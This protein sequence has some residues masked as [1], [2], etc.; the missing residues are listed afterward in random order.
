M[1][2]KQIPEDFQ[3]EELTAVQAQDRGE[4]AF[5]RLEKV[6]WTT[7]DA[8]QL[9]AR[10]WKFPWKAVSY[11]GLKDR[12]ASTIQYL[13][14]FRGPRRNFVQDRLR[15]EYLGQVFDPFSSRDMAGNRFQI[16][17]RDLTGQQ[18]AEVQARLTLLQQT[19]IPNYFDD[20]RFGSVT[21]DGRFVAKEMVFGRFEAALKLALIE[22][23]EFDN[24]DIK[25]EK[26]ILREHWNDWPTCKGKLPRSHARSLVDYLVHH[27][28]DYRGTLAR[29]RPELQGMYLSAYQSDLW[30]RTL[31]KWLRASLEPSVLGQIQLHHQ[32]LVVPVQSHD[33]LESLKNTSIALACPRLKPQIDAPWWPHLEAVLAEEGLTLKQLKIP[34]LNKPFFSKGDRPAFLVP[35][36]SLATTEVDDLNPRKMKVQ[37]RFD[38]PRGS[39]ATMI[40]KCLTQLGTQT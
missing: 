36:H 32:N 30:N 2:I 6:N 10:H 27:P 19:G 31:D 21:A 4:F 29:T 35:T 38:L 14:I 3:V 34:G 39:Y 24:R 7:P 25:A 17:V 23:Y 8:I 13:T 37:L 33:I 11:G 16:V 20:Q 28:T 12:H 18:T 22:P 26:A 15:L 1:K 9:I 40:L 5:Y